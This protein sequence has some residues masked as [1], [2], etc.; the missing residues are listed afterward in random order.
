MKQGKDDKIE[1]TYDNAL[2]LNKYNSNFM[3]DLA[4]FLDANGV[5]S[6]ADKTVNLANYS[7]VLALMLEKMKVDFPHKK[8]DPSTGKILED[9]FIDKMK[10]D[11]LG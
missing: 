9:D 2:I 1:E 4:K 11:F 3:S 10:K 7:M 5:K 6:L 8:I